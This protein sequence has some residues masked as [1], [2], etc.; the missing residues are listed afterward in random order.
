MRYLDEDL[1]IDID[2]GRTESDTGLYRDSGTFEIQW[3]IDISES[4]Q[5]SFKGT[6]NLFR[7]IWQGAPLRIH[8]NDFVWNT[9]VPDLSKYY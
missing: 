7:E 5:T 3:H 4:W 6:F 1:Y 9:K 2:F 8:I